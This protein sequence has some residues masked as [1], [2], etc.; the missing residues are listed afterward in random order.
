MRPEFQ[1][2]LD[3]RRAPEGFEPMLQVNNPPGV[4]YRLRLP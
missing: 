3:P 2:L 4:L 1:F